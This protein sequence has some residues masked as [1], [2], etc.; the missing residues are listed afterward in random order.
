MS[1]EQ[2]LAAVVNAANNLTNTV[3]GKVGEI[4]QAIANSRQQYDSQL[5]DLKNRLPRL[6][7]TKN[8][9]LMP[10]AAGTAIDGWGTHELVTSTKLRTISPVSQ[11]MG[12]AVADVEFMLK[13]QADVREQYPNFDIR[14]TE[15]WRGAINVWQMKWTQ[16]DISPWLAFPY[17]SDQTLA[18]GGAAVP[19]NSYLT[20][21]AFVRVVEGSLSG[22][23]SHGWEKGKW[24]WCS[25]VMSPSGQF[26][27]YYHLHPVR[28]SSVG[29]VEI[30][31]A[32][33]CTGVVTEPGDWGTM[34][35]IS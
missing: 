32:G 30:M 10:N 22:A 1:T 21:G 13:V 12:R 20:L 31:L 34:L 24:R 35:A 27:A 33:A 15:Y 7:V 18:N 8:F 6:A 25:T 5:A 9:T 19:L 14:A 16:T 11:T 29:L 26:G 4:D 17:V 2:Q 23:W 28:T 3:T